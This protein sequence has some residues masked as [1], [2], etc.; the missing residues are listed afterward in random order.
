MDVGNLETS[1]LRGVQ[2]STY[3]PPHRR[4]LCALCVETESQSVYFLFLFSQ[5]LPTGKPDLKNPKCFACFLPN[6]LGLQLD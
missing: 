3:C 4:N 1:F 5:R 6:H 2:T